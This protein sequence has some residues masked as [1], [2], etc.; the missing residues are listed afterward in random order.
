MKKIIIG[1]SLSVV[2]TLT[3]AASSAVCATG[4]GSAVDATTGLTGSTAFV[5]TGFTPKCSANT[6]VAFAQSPNT[7]AVGAIST[8]GNQIFGGHTNGGAV[9]KTADC[10]TSGCVASDA[11]SAADTM[12]TQS[13]S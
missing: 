4:T 11:T 10:A 9:A 12:L 2:S 3:F 5:Q 8:K 7:A 1:L 6:S 13:S